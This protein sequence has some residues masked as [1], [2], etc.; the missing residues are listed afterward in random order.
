VRGTQTKQST[1]TWSTLSTMTISDSFATLWRPPTLSADAQFVL[2]AVLDPI[3]YF[4]A[5]LRRMPA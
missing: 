2:A 1:H 4:L 5:R 3:G